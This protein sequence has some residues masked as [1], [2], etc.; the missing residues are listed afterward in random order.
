MPL[1]DTGLGDHF[2]SATMRAALN[3][4]YAAAGLDSLS[5][6]HAIGRRES[7]LA[8]YDT[9]P[10]MVALIGEVRATGQVM[11]DTSAAWDEYRAEVTVYLAHAE[12]DDATADDTAEQYLDQT[13]A[14]IETQLANTFND[15]RCITT[16]PLAARWQNDL[17]T[18]TRVVQLQFAVS[19]WHQ[20]GTA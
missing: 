17:M 6:D 18:P 1:S 15:L 8:A 2:R 14:T 19:V 11:S 10:S 9:L 3:T 13:R 16:D 20:R 12:G 4:A 7:D 5:T